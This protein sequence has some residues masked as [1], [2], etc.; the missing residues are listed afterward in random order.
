MRLFLSM[1]QAQALYH[2]LAPQ[3]SCELTDEL[4]LVMLTCKD[5]RLKLMRRMMLSH[6]AEKQYTSIKFKQAEV[7]ALRM[8][9]SRIGWL[10]PLADSVRVY[11]LMGA[12]AL[13]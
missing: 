1:S 13:L 8:V 11:V 4:V 5:I 10:E 7:F 6:A 12:D 2:L 9:L 3:L